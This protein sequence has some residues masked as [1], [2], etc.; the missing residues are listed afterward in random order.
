MPE[1]R[2]AVTTFVPKNNGELREFPNG[3]L[4]ILENVVDGTSR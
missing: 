1:G 3:T 2:L 4:W